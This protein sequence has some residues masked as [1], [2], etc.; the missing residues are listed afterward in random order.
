MK[1]LDG[2]VTWGPAHVIE[3]SM[4]DPLLTNSGAQY[5]TAF[6]LDA[7]VDGNGNLHMAVDLG[8][9]NPATGFSLSAVYGNYGVFDVFTQDGGLTYRAKLLYKPETFRGTF[10]VSATDVTNPSI[11]EDNRPQASRTYTGGN[12]LFFTWFSTD[13]SLGGASGNIYPNMWSVGYDITT[14]MWTAAKN[15]T[16]G[17][18]IDGKII[19]GSVSYYVL[20][21]SPGVYTIPCAYSGFK[22]SDPTL[23]GSAVQL[24]YIDSA[25]FV[26]ADFNMPDNSQLLVA[27]I[28]EYKNNNLSIS[29]NYPNPFSTSTMIDVTLQKGSDMSIQVM[30]TLGQ[31]V[32]T[33]LVKSVS[34]GVHTFTIDGSALSP[35]IYMY[36]VKTADSSITRKMTVK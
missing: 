19:Q 13:S 5:T 33:Q 29:Q 12:Q 34:Q 20:S 16:G 35:G 3:F 9:F 17:T 27:G 30:N 21:P 23:T 36:T 10:G 26:S 22:N 31:V 1:T 25:Q 4:I 14:N 7:V 6:D 2:G 8:V 15:F 32:S 11:S 24:N 28:A 18:S